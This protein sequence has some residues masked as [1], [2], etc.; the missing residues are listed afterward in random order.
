MPE[1]PV[2]LTFDD[3]YLTNL[4]Y[5]LPILEK[6]NAKAV[7]SIVGEYTDRFT[8]VRDRVLS[9]AHLC[10][11]D[12]KALVDSPFAEIQNHSYNMHSLKGRRGVAKKKGES[13]EEYRKVLDND[14]LYM[15]KLIQE[16]TGYTP[17]TFTYPFG[18]LSSAAEKILKEMGFKATL[19]CTEGM[20]VLT[21][22]PE[23]LYYMRRYNRPCNVDRDKFFGRFE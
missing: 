6:H 16:K 23:D 19:T 11:E 22:K 14:I 15:Q 8:N 13:L 2:V 7:F 18:E 10:W 17:T 12:V 3:G 20:N 1:K 9:Y 21:G 4:E 5:I